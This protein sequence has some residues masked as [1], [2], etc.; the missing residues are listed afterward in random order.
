MTL[1]QKNKERLGSKE[2]RLSN[3]YKIR[4]KDGQLIT[5]KKNRAQEDFDKNK[6]NR[7]ILLKSRQLG[8]TTLEAIDM[9]DECLWTR[10]YQGLFIA[11][12]LD[13]AK[14]IL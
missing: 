3:L 8:F 11:Q 10:N 12:D 9:L 13:T 5:F 14:E 4:N 1:S 2:W 6:H 7:N